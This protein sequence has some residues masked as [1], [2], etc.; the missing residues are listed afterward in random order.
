MS[1]TIKGVRK[2][3]PYAGQHVEAFEMPNGTFRS[4]EACVS[5]LIGKHNKS[6]AEWLSLQPQIA[7]TGSGRVLRE[8]RPKQGVITASNP[9]AASA[10]IFRE[11]DDHKNSKPLDLSVV[12]VSYGQGRP[13]KTV[14]LEAAMAYWKSWAVRGDE[15]AI[16]FLTAAAGQDF[17]R[18]IEKAF[19][20]DRTE[21]EYE[22]RRVEK[23]RLVEGLHY[24]LR[25]ADNRLVLKMEGMTEI[26]EFSLQQSD[27]DLLK[28]GVSP[29]SIVRGGH[30]PDD[31]YAVAQHFDAV[32]GAS[33]H[34]PDYL[35]QK[36]QEKVVR[37]PKELNRL[38]EDLVVLR[39]CTNNKIRGLKFPQDFEKYP[40]LAEQLRQ[41]VHI[42]GTFS[43]DN[44]RKY[45]V[46]R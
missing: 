7:E 15:D 30:N 27:E 6:Y 31:W 35:I 24:T 18:T 43:H 16:N 21:E 9:D 8:N 25:G 28:A 42:P 1:N 44:W 37:D 5:K 12:T 29:F 17:E 2:L 34:K 36:Q 11:D 38:R 10:L 19:G 4:G 3:V 32:P 40:E 41:F 45:L 20:V 46:V 33:Y 23:L 26:R 13:S 22:K 14:T 39:F